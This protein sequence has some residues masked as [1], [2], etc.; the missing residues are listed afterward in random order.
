VGGAGRLEEPGSSIT[1]SCP[2]RRGGGPGDDN[3]GLPNGPRQRPRA[4][5][6]PMTGNR[7]PITRTRPFVVLARQ[8]AGQFLFQNGFDK[9]A[10]TSM[11][12]AF[13]GVKPAVE[14]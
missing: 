3:L 10:H 4:I 11:K 14:K 2:T 7:I 9:A 1:S 13:Y 8:G 6:V 12:A 5:A